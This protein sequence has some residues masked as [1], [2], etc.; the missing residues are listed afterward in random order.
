MMSEKFTKTQHHLDL[1]LKTLHTV[2]WSL[3][4]LILCSILIGVNL[5]AYR[6]LEK[7]RPTAIVS[8]LIIASN[9][10]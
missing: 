3:G 7:R 10:K 1:N 4:T 5:Q 9:R 8:K 6:E 2:A